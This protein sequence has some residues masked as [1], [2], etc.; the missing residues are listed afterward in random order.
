MNEEISKMLHL[1]VGARDDYGA[2]RAAVG[3]P[4][5][6]EKTESISVLVRAK[7]ETRSERIIV[8][9]HQWSSRLHLMNWEQRFLPRPEYT[10][11]EGLH[12]MYTQCGHGEDP[13]PRHFA[14]NCP[15][16]KR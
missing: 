10:D 8:P 14:D 13:C 4:Q 3:I 16:V 9:K 12:M 6:V 7:N 11:G 15:E 1:I 2:F 5:Y